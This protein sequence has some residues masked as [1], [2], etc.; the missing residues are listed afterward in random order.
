MVRSA[1]LPGIEGQFIVNMRMKLPIGHTSEMP[2]NFFHF[3]K[4]T[5][6]TYSFYSPHYQAKLI[7]PIILNIW[8]ITEA[9]N[10]CHRTPRNSDMLEMTSIP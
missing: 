7:L 10:L 3:R 9:R 4:H 6:Q 8:Q 2:W 5:H 1:S